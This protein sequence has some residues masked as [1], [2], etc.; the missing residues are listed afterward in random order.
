MLIHNIYLACTC[1][2]INNG[3]QLSS[4]CYAPTNRKYIEFLLGLSS[5]KRLRNLPKKKQ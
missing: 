2:E 4:N 5:P 3:K 1:V